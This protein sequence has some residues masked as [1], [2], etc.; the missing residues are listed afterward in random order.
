MQ[1]LAQFNIGRLTYDLDDPKVADFVGGV[2]ML[3][4]IADRS[5]GFVWKYETGAGGVVQ[6]EVDDDP[7]I[8]VNLTV[9]ESVEDLRHFVYKTL[10]KHFLLR[11]A[12]WFRALDRAHFVMWWIPAGHQPDLAEA[13]ARLEQLRQHGATEAAFDWSWLERGERQLG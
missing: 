8:V 3:N 9:W 12:E 5:D 7:R 4:R 11:K 6:D 2:D 13:R 1:H 10:H